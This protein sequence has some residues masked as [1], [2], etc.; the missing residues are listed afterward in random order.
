MKYLA[1]AATGL[2]LIAS[3]EAGDFE[4]PLPAAVGGGSSERA[5]I[6]GPDSNWD[7]QFRPYLWAADLDGTI[8]VGRQRADIDISFGDYLSDIEAT[9]ASTIDVRRKGS[10]WSFFLDTLYL[11]LGP[12]APQTAGAVTVTD[13]TI[14]Q[15]LIDGWVGYRV[16]EW[17]E[18]WF[19][20]LGGLRYQSLDNEIDF[21][22]AGVFGR[23]GGSQDWLDPHF[24]A[25]AKHY[26]SPKWY[27]GALID[28]GGFGV[29]SELSVETG[30]GFGYHLSDC[31]ALELSYRFLY[32]DYDSASFVYDVKTHGIFTGLAFYF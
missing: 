26:L 3:V 28:V 2:T 13:V 12:D 14:E 6:L 25:R 4:E 1:V 5:T 32:V 22:N 20:L 16:A 8:G 19:D 7:I 23:V 30:A 11:K 9:W 17:D 15:L 29:G 21:T 24:G 27:C 18:G 10:R 31:V